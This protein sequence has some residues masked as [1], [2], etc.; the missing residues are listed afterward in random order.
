MSLQSAQ[1]PL[2]GQHSR[3]RAPGTAF[4]SHARA[5]PRSAPQE[6]E[7]TGGAG[8]GKEA[9]RPTAS[10]TLGLIQGRKMP[11]GTTGTTGHSTSSSGAGRAGPW[12]RR[13]EQP[14]GGGRG[15][16]ESR[17]RDL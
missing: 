1:S 9:A 5:G 12:G 2:R 3:S 13:L 6:P 11:A 8:G 4:R 14:K 10:A 7:E 17:S 16:M 15:L